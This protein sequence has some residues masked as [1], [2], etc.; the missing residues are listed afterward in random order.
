MR[1]QGELGASEP[2]GRPS[3]LGGRGCRFEMALRPR[4]ELP[5]QPPG[6]RGAGRSGEAGEGEPPLGARRPSKTNPPMRAASWAARERPEP[7][8]RARAGAFPTFPEDEAGNGGKSTVAGERPPACRG[9]VQLAEAVTLGLACPRAR[10]MPMPATKRSSRASAP[11]APHQAE[12]AGMRAAATASSASGRRVASGVAR[13][14]GTPKSATACLLPARSAS[15]AAPATTKT[16]ASSK[17]A[18]SSAVLMV[19]LL[20]S[21]CLSC[22]F[23][24]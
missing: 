8:H 1:P 3:A 7:T 14:E 13:E 12:A 11:S 9:R 2:T 6:A 19:D 18:M 23:Y 24:R 4:C 5:P 21:S 16:T 17:R 22:L 15:F 10:L 20:T